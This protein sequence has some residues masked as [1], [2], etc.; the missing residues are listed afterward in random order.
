MKKIIIASLLF[1]IPSYVY[2]Q[3]ADP[4]VTINTVDACKSLENEIDAANEESARL[5]TL[6]SSPVT[7]DVFLNDLYE[8][9]KILTKSG[10]LFFKAADSHE[11]ACKEKLKAAGDYDGILALYDRYLLPVQ[12]ARIF[13]KKAREAAV[14]LNRQDDVNTFN[15]TMLEYDSAIMQLVGVCEA[16]LADTPKRDACK[17]LSAK[18]GDALN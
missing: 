13:F 8:G 5:D 14:S 17:S 15:K 2:A 16:D 7:Q 6:L 1:F 10:D 4:I 12:K 18:L 11:N 9:I 3:S